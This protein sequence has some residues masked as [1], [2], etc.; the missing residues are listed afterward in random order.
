MVRCT[1]KQN[2]KVLVCTGPHVCI[3]MMMNALGES[4]AVFDIM[5]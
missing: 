3:S 2:M 5:Q 4:N 1:A